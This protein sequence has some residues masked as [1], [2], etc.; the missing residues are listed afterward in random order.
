M[1]VYNPVFNFT[2]SK[3]RVFNTESLKKIKNYVS[4]WTSQIGQVTKI[5][6]L[7]PGFTKV[8]GWSLWFALCNAFSPLQ[9]ANHRDHRC[10]FEKQGTKSKFLVNHRDHPC[11]LLLIKI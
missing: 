10:T 11:T 4:K 1:S 5:L 7:V 2:L 3:T 8:R 6:G 9:S